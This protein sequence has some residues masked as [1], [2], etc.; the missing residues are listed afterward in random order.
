MIR[1]GSPPDLAE[2]HISTVLF[3]ADRAYKLLKPVRTGFLDH[4]ET[5]RR[6]AAVERELELN[7]RL[8]PDVYLG[9]ADLIEGDELVDRMLIMRRL[10]HDRRLTALVGTTEFEPAIRALARLVAS[11]HSRLEPVL[12][13]EGMATAQGL[14][15]LWDSGFEEIEPSVGEVIAR[16]EHETVRRLVHDYLDHRAA[17]F[18]QRREQGMVRDGHGDLTAED[19]FILDDGPRV[20]DCLAFDDSL[21]ISDVLADIGFL[22]M[23]VHRLAGPDAASRLMRWYSE[24]S[25]EHHPSSLAHHYVA[26]RAHVRAKVEIIRHR[27]GLDGAA[28][29]AREYHRLA[30]DHLR[31][32]QLRLV[33]LGGGTGSGKTTLAH[34]VADRTGWLVLGSDELR[35]DLWGLAHHEHRHDEPWTGLYDAATTDR[36]YEALLEQ[37]EAALGAGESIVLDASWTAERHRLQARALAERES[38]ELV[39]LECTAPPGVAK[40]RIARRRDGGIDASDAYGAIV[41]EMASQRDPW[42]ERLE[43]DT[44]GAIDDALGQAFAHLSKRVGPRPQGAR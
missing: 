43:I 9:T 12:E 28:D 29:S 32:S 33:L 41:D 25:G 26:Y 37:A 38:V 44:S 17:L 30:F 15:A 24:F 27:Q 21:R 19:I 36:T 7:Q 11:F 20:L 10:P 42:P 34:A 23:D 1:T 14:T 4:S 22:A 39:E 35:K 18:D 5:G 31:R 6:V 13:P 40:S 16:D 3:V 2:T 8:A